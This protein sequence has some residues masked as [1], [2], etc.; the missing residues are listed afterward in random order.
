MFEPTQKPKVFVFYSSPMHLIFCT[1]PPDQSDY[2]SFNRSVD[3]VMITII[4]A[5][6]MN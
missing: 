2:S 1:A 6:I 5:K 4:K 3:D